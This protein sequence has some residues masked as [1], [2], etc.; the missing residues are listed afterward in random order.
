[1]NKERIP[2]NYLPDGSVDFGNGV[3][4]PSTAD[5]EYFNSLNNQGQTLNKVRPLQTETGRQPLVDRLLDLVPQRL[6]KPM[7]LMVTAGGIGVLVAACKGGGSGQEVKTTPTNP[8]ETPVPTQTLEPIPTPT[9]KPTEAPTVL[10]TEVPVET[11]ATI[12]EVRDA[13]FGENG[14]YSQLDSATLASLPVNQTQ[15]YIEE[16]LSVCNGEVAIPDIPPE[17]PNYGTALISSCT[18]IPQ[19]ING[20]PGREDILEFSVALEML[21]SFTLDKVDKLWKDGKFPGATE[22]EI[23]NYK[24]GVAAYFPK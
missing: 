10:P 11:P 24:I 20:I 21:G 8:P 22:E 4:G 9:T 19:E 1:M 6:K 12:E 5:I 14:A 7:M 15:A 17:S 18:I 23:Q 2:Q 16:R 3:I 13:F